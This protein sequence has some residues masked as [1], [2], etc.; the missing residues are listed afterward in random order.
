MVGDAL[1]GLSIGRS[2]PVSMVK[3]KLWKFAKKNSNLSER[4]LLRK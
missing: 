3:V 4:H 1:E 2:F